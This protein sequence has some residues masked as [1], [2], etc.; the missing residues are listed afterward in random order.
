M[1]EEKG[2]LLRGIEEED[3]PIITG[4]M[5]NP[6]FKKFIGVNTIENDHYVLEWLK[7]CTASQTKLNLL[8]GLPENGSISGLCGFK[9]IDHINAKAQFHLHYH[10]DND[11]NLPAE[12]VLNVTLKFIFNKYN[13]NKIYSHMMTENLKT[14]QAYQEIGFKKEGVL[15]KHICIDGVH[16]DITVLS[17]LRREFL[18][19]TP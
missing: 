18:N 14:I 7:A 15:R 3:L 4:W 1:I 12:D 19:K 5:S 11:K 16:K 9:N 6:L 17:I 2:V 10:D 13:L 8:F